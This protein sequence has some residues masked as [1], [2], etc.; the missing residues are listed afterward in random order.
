MTDASKIAYQSEE[1]HVHSVTIKMNDA[2]ELTLR[3]AHPANKAEVHNMTENEDYRSEWSSQMSGYFSANYAKDEATEIAVND[4]VV[5]IAGREKS[6]S[7]SPETEALCCVPAAAAP[8]VLLR[9]L[10]HV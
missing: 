9:D 1:K 10:R 6:V 3:Y 8:T 4:Y 2:Q 5:K 7:T